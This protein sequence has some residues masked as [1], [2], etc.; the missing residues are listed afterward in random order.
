LN[1]DNEEDIADM[2]P[3]QLQKIREVEKKKLDELLDELVKQEQKIATERLELRS[4]SKKMS[5][6]KESLELQIANL[7]QETDIMTLNLRD[8]EFR[9]EDFKDD[10]YE[11]ESTTIYLELQE[12]N[13]ELKGRSTVYKTFIQK[14]RDE[15]LAREQQDKERLIEMLEDAEDSKSVE[16][17]EDEEEEEKE[18]DSLIPGVRL[19]GEILMA[20]AN[21]KESYALIQHNRLEIARLKAE[22]KRGVHE[23]TQHITLDEIEEVQDE[24]K[25]IHMRA[26]S[27]KENLLNKIIEEEESIL[28]LEE[29]LKQRKEGLNPQGFWGWMTGQPNEESDIEE[30][31]EKEDTIDTA[32]E[33]AQ[34]TLTVTASV[35]SEHVAEDIIHQKGDEM[36]KKMLR[37]SLM[38]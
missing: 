26:L 33:T 38:V 23:N 30:K 9:L 37:E 31:D 7:K 19:R 34:D 4:A 22:F 8:A 21:L 12:E 15:K 29:E 35:Y 32:Q 3:E 18:G 1:N 2:D 36:M 24:I 25:E 28:A 10:E 11:A 5:E 27:E 20:A 17:H 14:L 6:E 16:F 13:A